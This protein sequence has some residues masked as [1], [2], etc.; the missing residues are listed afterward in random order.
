MRDRIRPLL[1]FFALALAFALVWRRVRIIFVVH[2]GW[3]QVLAT[4]LVLACII[5]LL[6]HFILDRLT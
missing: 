5:Y 4:V 3:L 6:L 2:M 1:W